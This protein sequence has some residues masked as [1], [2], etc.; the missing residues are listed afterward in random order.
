MVAALAKVREAVHL[1]EM[2]LPQIETGS[3][4]HKAVI[5]AIQKLG[6]A[7][8]ASDEIPGVQQSAL[9]DLQQ[10]AQQTAALRQLMAQQQ[11]QQ[12]PA[13]GATPPPEAA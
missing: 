5:D 4:Q 13:G 11:A 8:P 7:V 2:A 12:P 1:L 6:K 3:D 10:R 9:M